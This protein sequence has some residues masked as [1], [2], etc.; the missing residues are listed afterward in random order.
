MKKAHCP[1]FEPYFPVPIEV[2]RDQAKLNGLALE[3][4]ASI[5]L[6][7]EFAQGGDRHRFSSESV[8][9]RV[10]PIRQ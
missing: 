3:T 6:V 2:L 4:I 10:A 8:K 5:V 9:L 1:P 7:P